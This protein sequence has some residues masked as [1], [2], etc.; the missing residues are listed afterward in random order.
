MSP[1]GEIQVQ[2][3]WKRFKAD[4]RLLLRDE[5]QR[6]LAK[7][8]KRPEEGWRWVLRDINLKIAPGE[9]VGLIGINGS[10]KTTLLKLMSKVMFPYSGSVEYS[11]RVGALL[12]VV[13]GLHHDLSGREN[14]Y[15][16]GSLLGWKRKDIAQRFEEIVHFAELGPAID[17]QVKFYSSG[18]QMRLAFSIASMLDPQILLVD[19]VLAVGDAS[20]Q[21]KSL[22]RM[23]EVLHQGATLVYVSHDL[24]TVQAM[25]KRCIWLNNGIIEMDG[26]TEEV[27]ESYLLSLEGLISIATHSSSEA[28]LENISITGKAGAPKTG[29]EVTIELLLSS[30]DAA[31]SKCYLG[32][33]QTP[34]T[35]SF[36]VSSPVTLSIGINSLTCQLD[37]LPVP[38]GTAF[39]WLGL[40]G[41]GDDPI[42][43]FQ[44]V[45]Q[46][47]IS[48]SP[49]LDYPEGV[50]ISSPLY[51]DS[52][53]TQ[54][55]T[56]SG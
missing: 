51:I 19:E 20:F 41:P 31:N 42:L 33:G 14:V 49:H 15:I 5:T 55:F 11:G 7:L 50:V 36:V 27:I 22:A 38:G 29:E 16:Y 26:P 10:G 54:H 18:M 3:L 6:I 21:Q 37:S 8:R 25:C 28:T 9:S 24:A 17:R 35:P 46:F 47:E 32:I 23:R 44:V 43:Q 52:H 2:H 1:S 12:G 45:G 34:I 48:G 56:K 30:R 13:A 40:L 4:H 39:I 53:W